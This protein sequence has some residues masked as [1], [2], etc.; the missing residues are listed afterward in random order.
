MDI[1][2]DSERMNATLDPNNT[3]LTQLEPQ[4][5]TVTPTKTL[6]QPS[7]TKLYTPSADERQKDL[8]KA[9]HSILHSD[10]GLAIINT[11]RSNPFYRLNPHHFFLAYRNV[12]YRA[13][14]TLNSL[15]GLT[16]GKDGV[17]LEPEELINDCPGAQPLDVALDSDTG[18][19]GIDV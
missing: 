6:E 19:M 1:Y 3:S 15:T 14:H 17:I 4:N 2:T 18:I 16:E 9:L 7:T 12:T 8:Q 13:L 11:P 10:G 5:T